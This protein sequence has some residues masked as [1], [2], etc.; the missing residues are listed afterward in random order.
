MPDRNNLRKEGFLLAH[1]FRGFSAWLFG[2][3]LL[4]RVSWQWEYVEV[5][6]TSWWTGSRERQEGARDK[7]PPRSQP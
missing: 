1:S 2:P 6:L 4:G 7:I 5:V 3:M